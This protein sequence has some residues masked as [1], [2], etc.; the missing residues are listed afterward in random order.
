MHG[1]R[2]TDFVPITK[3]C[4]YCGETFTRRLSS[5]KNQSF[6]SA[7][8]FD[9]SRRGVQKVESPLHGRK[10]YAVWRGIKERCLNPSA[11]AY[12][13]YG[14]RGITICESWINSYPAFESWSIANGYAEGL[15][16]ERLDNNGPYSPENCA[17]VDRVA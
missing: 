8:C 6:C 4:T 11:T 10:L 15:S 12:P 9:D 2:Y 5:D 3:D 14:G 13:R 7:K 17:F 16:I 1:N